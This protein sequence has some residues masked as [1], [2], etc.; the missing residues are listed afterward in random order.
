M[1]SAEFGDR[2]RSLRRARGLT[3]SQL[4]RESGISR[5]F[6]GRVEQGR[7]DISISRLVK[8]ARVYDITLDDLASDGQEEQGQQVRLVRHTQEPTFRTREAEVTI[9]HR[10]TGAGLG[11]ALF[12]YRMGSE[13]AIEHSTPR[14]TMIFVLQGR[15]AVTRSDLR[16]MTL[17]EGDS[18]VFRG[19]ITLNMACVDG[20]PGRF[21]AL[22]A[23]IGGTQP[24]PSD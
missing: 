17:E 22:G 23:G 16:P 15:F 6:L 19:P 11:A 2:L 5:S 10:H 14:E 8:L 20:A 9:I 13:V 1:R 3:L 18:L 21:L 4:E 12:A 24:E 7:S